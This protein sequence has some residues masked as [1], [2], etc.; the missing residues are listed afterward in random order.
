MRLSILERNAA[1]VHEISEQTKAYCI[2]TMNQ[3]TDLI[4]NKKGF[5]LF[6]NVRRTYGFSE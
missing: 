6:V 4:D 5:S 1:D 3:L 2:L